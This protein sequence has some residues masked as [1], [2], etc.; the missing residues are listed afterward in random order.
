MT[1]ARVLIRNRVKGGDDHLISIIVLCLENMEH[2]VGGSRASN[3]QGCGIK[4]LIESNEPVCVYTSKLGFVRGGARERPVSGCN[5]VWRDWLES[6]TRHNYPS[7][8]QHVEASCPVSPREDNASPSF[9][10][11]L[12]P[13]FAAPSPVSSRQ[14]GLQS[15]RLI[16]E[17]IE[18][19]VCPSLWK[20]WRQFSNLRRNWRY[21][22]L[23][24]AVV[25]VLQVRRQ[26]R[27]QKG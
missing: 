10:L 7:C 25:R 20:F 19:A 3:F 12:P 9:L 8:Q 16:L 5:F 21:T 13:A 11:W 22:S 26:K 6:R 1:S 18:R 24:R 4:G 14:Y 27:V 15:S 17:F 2:F 23:T